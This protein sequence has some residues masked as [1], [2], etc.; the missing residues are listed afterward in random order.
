MKW[1]QGRQ[2]PN[3]TIQ[4]S[5]KLQVSTSK[6]G[7]S[8]P[9]SGPDAKFLGWPLVT[10]EGVATDLGPRHSHASNRMWLAGCGSWA[11]KINPVRVLIYAFG[12]HQFTHRVPS[13]L[14]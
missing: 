11:L 4:A 14:H 9:D 3:P 5:E 6:T 13:Y 1:P 12:L 2:A 7:V 10:Q 8:A